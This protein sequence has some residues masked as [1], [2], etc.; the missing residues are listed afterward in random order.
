MTIW[1]H[2]LVID[3][4]ISSTLLT[5]KW[6]SKMPMHLLKLKENKLIC[7]RKK[8]MLKK[9]PFHISGHFVCRVTIFSDPSVQQE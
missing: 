7:R 2:G 4:M 8:T 9:E 6:T 5:L 1:N 3:V